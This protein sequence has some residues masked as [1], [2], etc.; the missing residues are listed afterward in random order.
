MPRDAV[1]TIVIALNAARR[2]AAQP[3]APLHARVGGAMRSVAARDGVSVGVVAADDALAAMTRPEPEPMRT[4]YAWPVASPSPRARRY[5]IWA[6]QRAAGLEPCFAMTRR[7]VCVDI[8]CAFRSECLA[9]RAVW[10]G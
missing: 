6:A 4:A 7:Y 8:D 10:Q 2:D 5:A 1:M 3:Y 9:L